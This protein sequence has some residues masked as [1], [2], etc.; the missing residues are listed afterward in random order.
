MRFDVPPPG[1]DR[2]AGTAGGFQQ[3][4]VH[5]KQAPEAGTFVQIVDVL[6]DQQEFARIAGLETGQGL[7]GG[8]GP[9]R[10]VGKANP[11]SVVGRAL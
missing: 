6:G 3:G 5:V 9:D 2:P 1:I 11:A 10:R 8:V 7:M 4:T